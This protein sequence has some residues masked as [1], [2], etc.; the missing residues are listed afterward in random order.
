MV[1]AIPIM[2]EK[3]EDIHVCLKKKRNIESTGLKSVDLMPVGSI[4]LVLAAGL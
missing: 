4:V 2:A 1:P 3:T